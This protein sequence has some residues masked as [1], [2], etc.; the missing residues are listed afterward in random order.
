MAERWHGAIMQL[1][2]RF[3]SL[4]A[5]SFNV[6]NL[7]RLLSLAMAYS[8]RTCDA[9]QPDQNR[10]DF[11]DWLYV[12]DGRDQPGHP[13][14]ATYTGLYQAAVDAAGRCVL[15]GLQTGWHQQEIPSPREGLMVSVD[16]IL[17][18]ECEA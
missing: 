18:P 16:L 4:Y 2:V 10:Q 6:P 14:H 9:V 11:L 17:R 12:L 7:A 15:Q 1:V 3:A 13:C 8:M 5:M